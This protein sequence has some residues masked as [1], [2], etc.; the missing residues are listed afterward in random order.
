L[1]T[2]ANPFYTGGVR[3][4]VLQSD[5]KRAVEILQEAG[6]IKEKDLQPD[7]KTIYLNKIFSKIHSL[8]GC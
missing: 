2:Q 7:K 3:L 5:L 4:Q 6:Y 1:A 8:F